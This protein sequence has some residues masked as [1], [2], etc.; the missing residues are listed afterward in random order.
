MLVLVHLRKGETLT[1]VAAGFGV[2]VGPA[3]R[4]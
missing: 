1:E 4:S 3:F 2:G